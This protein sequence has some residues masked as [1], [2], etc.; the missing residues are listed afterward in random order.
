MITW[1]VVTCF[2]GHCRSF[3]L[4]LLWLHSRPALSPSALTLALPLLYTLSTLLSSSARGLMSRE[5]RLWI[6][7]LLINRMTVDEW[8][9]SRVSHRNAVAFGVLAVRCAPAVDPLGGGSALSQRPSET[10][11]V[12]AAGRCPGAD[13]P[14]R[15]QEDVQMR[16][17]RIL[18]GHR[19]RVRQWCHW[20]ALYSHHTYR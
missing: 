14:Q 4:T 6:T 9:L 18:C 15:D 16:K 7:A 11:G 5:T 13:R 1:S 10:R 19:Q 3:S 2:S 20:S 17:R 8:F 12:S